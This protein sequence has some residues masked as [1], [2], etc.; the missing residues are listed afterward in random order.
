MKVTFIIK[1]V[2]DVFF[3]GNG[4][5]IVGLLNMA[6]AAK[7]AYLNRMRTDMGFTMKIGTGQFRDLVELNQVLR[8]PKS[9]TFKIEP[10]K[11]YKLVTFDIL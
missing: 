3:N 9:F 1:N 4:S 5:G 8:N 7:F 10:R 6:D 11:G 2:T